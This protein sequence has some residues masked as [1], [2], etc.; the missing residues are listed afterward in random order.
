MIESSKYAREV[1]DYANG[2]VEGRIIA[3][4][5]RVLGCKRFLR[6]IQDPR[7]E[8]R[9]KDADFVIGIIQTT[10]KHRQGQDLQARPLRGKAFLLEPWQKLC[11]YG[12]LIFYK[13]GTNERVVKEAM[14]FIPR[15]NGKTLLVSA[16]AYGLA[17]LERKSGAKVYVV[18]AQL[19]QSKETFDSWKYNLEHSLYDSKKE[20]VADG[21]RIADNSFEHSITHE[22]IAGGS[23]SLN[24]LPSN[25]DGQD[26]FNCNIVI[27]DEVHAYKTPKQ[28]NI[29]K[30]ATKAYT[31]K[32]VI[33]ITTAGD[34][35]TGFCAQRI[36][37]CRKVLNGTVEDDAYFIFLCCA[38]PEDDGSYDYTNPVTHEK[39]NP[40]YG[41]TIRPQDILNDALQAMNDPQQRKD[42]FAKSLNVFTAAV[43]AWFD[44]DEFRRSNEKAGQM[45]GIDPTWSVK[46]KLAKL[47]MLKID[48]YGGADLSKLHDLTACALHGQYK[49]IDI[50]IPHCWFPVVT[51]HKKADE[52][53]IP[54]F[55]W[56]EDGWLDL[57]NAPT[58]NHS[59]VVEWFK[60]MK[61][62]GF[63][64][65]QVGHDRKFCREYFAG[66]KAAGF[67]IIDQPQ[68]FYKKSEGFRHLEKQAKNGMLYYMGAEPYEY[69][70]QNVSA[71]EKTDDMI[72]YEKVHP[73]RRI[74]VFDADVFATVRMLE[75][76]EKAKNL[77]GWFDD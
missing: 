17:M 54:L 16:I 20:A 35:G 44:I 51:A 63:K 5:D 73:Q 13:P 52:D 24:A 67:N 57:C 19:K 18:G 66:M 10:Y 23:I 46:K 6:M 8:V 61:S 12:M 27:A 77:E 43:K 75:N 74:D 14:I 2:I 15:K 76:M 56:A 21:W 31:N 65:K 59:A 37:Y 68:Y 62:K 36:A 58:N 11:I 26:S 33:G 38:D 72:Q 1:L 53:S 70:V 28:Y 48:W 40:N 42:F 25:P 55:G 64:I 30:E 50:V 4:K 45:L 49:G 34:D 39:A 47:A 69:C 3:N 9:T 29:L 41:V 60:G 7:Y 71:I 32:L 22:N